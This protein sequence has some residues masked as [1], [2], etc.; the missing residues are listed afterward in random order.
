MHLSASTVAQQITMSL[1]NVSLT[2]ALS[3]IKSQSGY[4]FV[5]YTGTPLKNAKPVTISVKDAAL[6]KVLQQIFEEQP[7]S[8]QIESK[9]I[10]IREKAIPRKTAIKESETAFVEEQ[11]QPIRGR[12][13]NEKGEPLAGATVYVLDAEG[14]RTSL[15]TLSDD[16]G[17][18]RLD[19][20]QEGTF[21]E[22]SYLGYIPKK[23][24]SQFSDGQYP[25]FPF[26]CRD[27]RSRSSD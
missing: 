1:K 14:K 24:D 17:G 27:E 23:G 21:L 16:N 25:P 20:V 11:Q 7:M 4:G 18:F 12:V 8:Y 5:I 22:I 26:Y 9:T 13:T 2:K 15:Q 19:N 3:E 10:V 6:D